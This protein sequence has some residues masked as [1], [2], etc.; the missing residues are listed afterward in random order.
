MINN[1]TGMIATQDTNAEDFPERHDFVSKLFPDYASLPLRSRTVPLD[2]LVTRYQQLAGAAMFSFD[3]ETKP[4]VLPESFDI[5][6][7]LQ[8]SQ[9]QKEAYQHWQ[10]QFSIEDARARSTEELHRSVYRRLAAHAGMTQFSADVEQ[11]SCNTPISNA[12][13]MAHRA[14]Q[15][16]SRLRSRAAQAS[17]IQLETAYM[18]KISN[19]FMLNMSEAQMQAAHEEGQTTQQSQSSNQQHNTH[20]SKTIF[21]HKTTLRPKHNHEEASEQDEQMETFHCPY[22]A[23]HDLLAGGEAS[24][25]VSKDGRQ[26]LW[27]AH[28][29]CLESFVDRSYWRRHIFTPHHDLLGLGRPTEP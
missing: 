10:D 6:S 1:H 23:C 9:R 24:L 3:T 13:R 19:T 27:C 17:K 5:P 22:P 20:D 21:E 18:Q 15:E 11:A 29:G 16:V 14:Y 28:D 26:E 8:D 25:R 4:L 2:V 12:R 7:L